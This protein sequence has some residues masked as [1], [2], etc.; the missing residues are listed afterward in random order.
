MS[1]LAKHNTLI[2]NLLKKVNIKLCK[3]CVNP[4][5]QA[6]WGTGLVWLLNIHRPRHFFQQANR[7]GNAM[8][9]IHA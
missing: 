9:V 8:H 3:L 2:I 7:V 5:S 4:L 6:R 1:T